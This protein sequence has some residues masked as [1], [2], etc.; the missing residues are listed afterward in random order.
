MLIALFV[1]FFVVPVI[2]VTYAAIS[3]A[4]SDVKFYRDFGIK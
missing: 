4:I 3:D 1:I 2:A